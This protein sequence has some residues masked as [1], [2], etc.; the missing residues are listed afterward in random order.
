MLRRWLGRSILKSLAL[1]CWVPACLL[2]AGMVDARQ[3]APSPAAPPPADCASPA[4]L[5]AFHSDFWVNLHHFLYVSAVAAASQN[6]PH[7]SRLEAD[8]TATQQRLDTSESGEWNAVVAYYE[9][10]MVSRDLLFDPGMGQIKNQLEDATDS[11][12]LAQTDIPTTLKAMLLQA[13]PIYRKYWWPAQDSRNHRWIAG[14]RP[15]LAAH[16]SAMCEAL[17]KVYEHPWPASPVRVDVVGYANWAGAY[18][19]L[20]PVRITIT[21]TQASYQGQASLE[22][23]FHEASHGMV[24]KLTAAMEDAEKALDR[25]HAGASA[26]VPKTLWH[27]VLFYTAGQLAARQMPGYVPYAEKNGLWQ[28]AWPAPDYDLIARD[29]LPRIQGHAG[30]SQAA[31]SLVDDVAVQAQSQAR[32]GASG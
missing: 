17:T 10:S 1:G 22:M 31:T 8:D 5:F 23:V 13:A 20:A 2:F 7:P 27:A 11:S 21:S 15:L 26:A 14:L 3:P 12:D 4:A 32:R 25:Q 24:D 9:K 6:R 18:T 16:G 29:W 30:L 19:T 28:R